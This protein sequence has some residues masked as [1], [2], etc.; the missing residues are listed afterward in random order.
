MSLARETESS[1]ISKI[2][3]SKRASNF[4]GSFKRDSRYKPILGPHLGG[5][6]A[7]VLEVEYAM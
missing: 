1:F 2:G 5:V 6:E 3:T 7:N 4:K